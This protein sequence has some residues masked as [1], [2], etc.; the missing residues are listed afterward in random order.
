M[1]LLMAQYQVCKVTPSSINNNYN[2]A[3]LHLPLPKLFLVKLC[4]RGRKN[5]FTREAPANPTDWT[6]WEER[7]LKIAAPPT[8]SCPLQGLPPLPQ[9]GGVCWSVGRW[10]VVSGGAEMAVDGVFW[11]TKH[12]HYTLV[13]I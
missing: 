1:V 2:L 5:N 7:E 9:P 8:S 6:G 11:Y 4:Q 13:W 12:V 10:E 3:Q